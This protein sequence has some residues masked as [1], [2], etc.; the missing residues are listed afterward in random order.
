MSRFLG[1]RDFL[2]GRSRS[3][4]RLLVQ[5]Y[6]IP[7]DPERYSGS[8]VQTESGE[9][10]YS[11]GEEWLAAGPPRVELMLPP[12]AAMPEGW[13]DTGLGV[14][15]PLGNRRRITNKFDFNYVLDKM[16]GRYKADKS[17]LWTDYLQTT[18]VTAVGDLVG[19]VQDLSPA[20]NHAIQPVSANRATY[21]E[22]P[23]GA[24][25]RGWFD[26][27]GWPNSLIVDF[28][29]PG[30]GTF[31]LVTQWGI[32]DGGYATSDGE[33]ELGKKT[34]DNEHWYE[35]FFFD[36]SLSRIEI[37][38]LR[39]LLVADEGYVA[40]DTAG[41]TDFSKM[42]DLSEWMA[43]APMMNTSNATTVA[44]LFRACSNLATVPLYDFSNVLNASRLFE[45]CESLA[46]IPAIDMPLATNL[47][48]A[49][50]LCKAA[51]SFPSIDLSSATRVNA[52]WSRMISMVTFPAIDLPL[53][54]DFDFAWGITSA[55][56][57]FPNIDVSSG[58]TFVRTWQRSGIRSIPLL[59][60]S[61]AAANFERAFEGSNLGFAPEIAVSVP[62]GLFD[63]VSAANFTDAFKGC[64]LKEADVDNILV[65]IDTAS[66][67]QGINNG[68]LGL[69]G[70]TN[71]PP[72]AAGLT[73]KGNLEARGWTVT[74]N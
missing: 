67:N 1:D 69:Q 40:D 68:T 63:N 17:N 3:S 12:W 14:P 44:A 54:T 39:D 27:G 20:L 74:T 25:V 21:R 7:L 13:F 55:L 66:A 19:F 10:H 64:A 29:Q 59:N 57:N 15:S 41:R 37:D 24:G 72:G 48:S 35:I 73:A 52:A 5:P 32:F 53:C 26:F 8:W 36:S 71:A 61:A 45:G 42:F 9:M 62:A 34:R 18:Q 2:S 23:D 38:G 60:F 56:K 47:F 22:D 16:V 30:N 6:P 33:I 11:T 43:S 28:G 49:W 70:G 58:E 31:I 51:T 4:E 50:A 46:P 65:S